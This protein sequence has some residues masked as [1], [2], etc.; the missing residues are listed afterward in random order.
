MTRSP[1]WVLGASK[2]S[3]AR[4]RLAVFGYTA[5]RPGNLL[6]LAKPMHRRKIWRRKG[7]TRGPDLPPFPVSRDWI[8][9]DEPNVSV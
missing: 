8:S 6:V 1:A 3:Y 2:S 4:S 7:W 9:V 5:R